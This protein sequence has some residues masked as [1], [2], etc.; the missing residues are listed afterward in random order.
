[1]IR[2]TPSLSGPGLKVNLLPLRVALAGLLLASA[3]EDLRAADFQLFEGDGF[4]TWTIEGKGFGL[5]PSS[6][7]V[8]GIH[9]KFTG[10]IGNSFACSGNGGETAVGR[11]ISPVVTIAQSYLHFLVAGG[12]TSGK[13]A[14]QLIVDDKVVLEAMGENDLK[15]RPV[16]WDLS[17]WKG[18]KAQVRILDADTAPGGFIAADHFVFSD[19]KTLVLSAPTVVA[20]PGELVPTSVI[21]GYN[22][23]KGTR[24]EL[25]ATHE[26]Q[27][28]TSPTA[29]SFD[30]QGA[31][32]AAETHRLGA[33]VWDDR[34]YR[35]WYLDD[36]ASK[37]TAD[38]R[39]LHEKWKEKVSIESMTQK[40]EVVRRLVDNDGDG[41]ADA[42]TVFADQFNDVLDGTASGVLAYQGKVYFADIPK[43]HVLEDSKGTGVADKRGQ[44]AEGFGVHISLSGHDMNGFVLGMDGRIYGSIGDRGFNLVTRE[45]KTLTYNDQGS[46]FRFEPDGSNFEVVHAGLRNPKE[47]A[48]DEFGNGITVDNNADQG[49]PA[50]IIYLMEGVDSGWRIWN[51]A[52][53]T[54]REDI[55]LSEQPISA[56]LTE[57]MAELR[58]DK[59]P[60]FIVPPVGN[61]TSGPSGLAYYPGAGFL[62]SERGRFLICDYRASAKSSIW[63]FKLNPDGAGFKFNDAYQFS[64]GAC[65]TDL[66]YS[67][68]GRLF[69]ADFLGGWVATERGR[70]FSLTAE[71]EKNAGRTPETAALMKE[72]LE[73][74]S[75]AELIKLFAHP[76]QRIRMRAHIILAGRNS[77]TPLL[78]GA[79]KQGELM[80]RLHGIWGLGIRARKN[81]DQA[82]T[83]TLVALLADSQ[84]EVRAQAAHLLGEVAG[85]DPA[86]LMPLL[87]DDSLRVRSFAALS[88]G[89]LKAT[90]A[91]EPLVA[92]LAEN[93]DHDV[94]L[95][96][97]GMMGL[98]GSAGP[99]QIAGLKSHAS[100]SV[101]LVAVVALRRLASPALADFLND[102]DP[103]VSDEAIRSI[104]EAPAPAARPAL[105]AMLDA[106]AGATAP[107]PLP[108]MIARRLIHCAFRTGGKENAARLVTVASGKALEIGQRLEALRLL[109]Q[110]AKPAPVDQCLGKWDPL[111]DRDLAEIVPTL[112][113]GLPALLAADEVLLG[114]TLLL[115]EQLKLSHKNF[116]QES[117]LRIVRSSGVAGPARAT[118]LDLW[119]AGKP[120]DTDS[121]LLALATDPSDELASA[122][123]AGLA[124]NDPVKALA[125]A[126]AA[127]VSP[128]ASRR[129]G[130][131]KVIASIPGAESADMILQGLHKLISPQPDASTEIELLAAATGRKEPAVVAAL[132]AYQ[133]SLNPADPLAAAMP[134]LEGGDA[135]RGGQL[136]RTHGTAQ[137]VRCHRA[138]EGGHD[139]GGDAGPNLVGVAQ[140]NPDRRYLLESL[141]VPGAKVAAGYGIVSLTLKSGQTIGGTLNEETA[142]QFVVTAGTDVWSVKKSDIQS[143]TPAI[144]AMP[145]MGALLTPA[146]T[147]DIVA[148]L[149]T[150]TK[151]PKNKSKPP[152]P[153]PFQPTK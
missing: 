4:D 132:A 143:A 95:R 93:A 25:F 38:R 114:P 101:R 8:A 94:Y 57:K 107:R 7:E 91:F 133:K 92:M 30:E 46:V 144:S 128:S 10:Y 112:E 150:L 44:V 76:D 34:A 152:Q 113:A 142:D 124:K 64:T 33:G 35:F 68:D 45:G 11:L 103:R 15:F 14:V 40:S 80:A 134:S 148:F 65:A 109:L 146:E 149:A 73:T 28:V 139:L 16:A 136:F 59:Q 36:L 13:T 50:R 52:L 90:A 6:G 74:K 61:L 20:K 129:Q 78:I 130:A 70:I 21:P 131:W 66:E 72:G 48:F 24:L 83:A 49:D 105:N 43:I 127:L 42:M 88:L 85:C 77:S 123:L 2:R 97:A 41:K 58:N 54:F 106:Y 67:Y 120:Q 135:V 115:V 118:A 137:C 99:E 108:P 100:A 79:T 19:E 104:S 23:P 60:A 26:Q 32:Y 125:G 116:S 81:A 126:S 39:A 27:G 96:H 75:D 12:K 147:R 138:G 151:A 98:L 145:P 140:R 87:R 84:A 82:A 18:R 5:G 63:S 141:I 31:L 37:T 153:K 62:E 9:G 1:M 53:H 3:C 56:W 17:S 29:I 111:P 102:S 117:L 89:R 121:I 51:Q 122:A 119:L 22:I 47:I 110:W 86:N 71:S 55:G 69:V